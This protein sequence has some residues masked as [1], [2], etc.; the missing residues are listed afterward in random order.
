MSFDIDKFMTTQF[1][2]REEAVKVAELKSFFNGKKAVWKVRG[3]KGVEI[4]RA[5]ESTDKNKVVKAV[6][7]GLVSN[8]ER[9]KA[10]AIKEMLGVGENVPNDIA[11]R[12]ELLVMGSIEP[13][14]DYPLATKL[15][16][17]FPPSP[18]FW[19]CS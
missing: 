5:R 8:S 17:N 13:A 18:D 16:E 14:V 3:L 19:L 12:V 11:Y 10:D 6:V 15:C 4:A 9:K 2:P 7:D 1:T